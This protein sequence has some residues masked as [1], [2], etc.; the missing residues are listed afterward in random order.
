MNS[1]FLV[2]LVM[3]YVTFSLLL[4]VIALAVGIHKRLD[5]IYDFMLSRTRG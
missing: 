2:L 4:V 3:I 1:T 5:E